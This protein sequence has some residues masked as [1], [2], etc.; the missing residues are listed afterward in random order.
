MSH[1]KRN[2]GT[3]ALVMDPGP[4]SVAH[5]V[6]TKKEGNSQKTTAKL[7]IAPAVLLLLL[8]MAIPLGMTIYYSSVSFNLMI[9]GA[10]PFVGFENFY[11]F[12]T[13]PSFM[14]AMANTLVLVGSVLLIT[15]CLGT[16]IAVLINNPFPGRGLVRVLLISPFFIM[17]TVNALVW[18]NLLM[19]PVSGFFAYFSKLF[20]FE[21]IDWFTDAPMLAIIIIVSWQW[22]AFSILI[23]MTAMQSLDQD[24]MEA[25]RIDGAGPIATFRHIVIPHLQRPLTIV[26]MIETI[27]LLSI[28]AEIFTTTSGGPGTETTNLAYLIYSQALLQYDVGM[29]SAGGIIAV[30]L[31]NVVAIF[32]IRAVGKSL[33]EQ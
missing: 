16:L 19:H 1:L 7:L 25:A 17:P 15:V 23:L 13:D 3:T 10:K 6:P 28:F 8:W 18:K 21:P 33:A 22:L 2:P 31:A 5:N 20:G 4:A 14:A 9:P 30:I 29:A 12:F 11:Y 26:V 27:F 24:Q 32:L